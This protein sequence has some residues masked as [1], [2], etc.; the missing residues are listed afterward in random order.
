MSSR[1]TLAKAGQ[2]L[3]K[4]EFGE[5]ASTHG[6]EAAR[7]NR[8]RRE[9]VSAVKME[10]VLDLCSVTVMSRPDNFIGRFFLYWVCAVNS[11]DEAIMGSTGSGRLTDY[12]GDHG[13]DDKCEKAFA[14]HLEDV[15][16]C[17]YFK[18]HKSVPPVGT[19]L[20]VALK[21]RVVAQT[22]SGE[23]VGNLPTRFN[24]LAGCLRQGFSYTGQVRDSNSSPPVA[25]VRADFGVV[26]P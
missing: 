13:A 16:L 24:Y 7:G 5:D 8:A 22:Q 10:W 26:S 6:A 17:D 20:E 18:A 15:D 11:F 4:C 14:T 25:A 12:P 23:V 21:K 1:Q 19:V 2:L 9:R 3:G